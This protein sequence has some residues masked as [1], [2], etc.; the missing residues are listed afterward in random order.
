MYFVLEL[1][2]GGDLFTVQSAQPNY[3]LPEAWAKFYAASLSLARIGRFHHHPPLF[4]VTLTAHRS[5][6]TAHRS[7][8]SP[9][10]VTLTLTLTLTRRC[11]TSTPRVSSTAISSRRTC[12]STR[13]ASSSSQ[14]SASPRRSALPSYH[15]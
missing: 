2:R 14:T 11:G 1:A 15:P 12:C 7:P 8:L 6:L 9:S 4:T 3:M 10:P 13:T 5:P